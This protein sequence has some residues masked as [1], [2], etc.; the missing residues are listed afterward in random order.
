[1]TQPA[2]PIIHN[3]PP[4]LRLDILMHQDSK[5]IWVA[6]C[7]QLDLVH[8]GK[9]AE[10]VYSEA[11]QVCAEH[12]RFAM[13]HDNIDHLFVPPNPELYGKMLKAQSLGTLC[14]VIERTQR[15]QTQ[16]LEFQ[17]LLAKKAA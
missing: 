13:E 14:L 12:V 9:D 2:T 3:A 17:R 5:G 4:T 10:Q 1:M 7:L 16:V 11:R 6:H 15:H 8:S